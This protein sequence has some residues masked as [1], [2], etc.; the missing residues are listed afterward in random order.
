MAYMQ[1]QTQSITIHAHPDAGYAFVADPRTLPRWASTFAP[2]IRPAEN[3]EWII[4]SPAGEVRIRYDADPQR[5]T[6]DF[7]MRP[8]E[9]TPGIEGLAASRVVPNGQEAEYVF[10]MFRFDGMPDAV[11]QGQLEELPLELIRLKAAIE[12]A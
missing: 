11:W 10:T 3:D 1:S 5:R 9:P 2:R 6:V 7:D 8:V 4:P 12:G